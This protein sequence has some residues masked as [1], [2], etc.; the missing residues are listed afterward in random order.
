MSVVEGWVGVVEGGV[1]VV[2]GGAGCDRGWGW[3]W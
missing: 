3:V 2:K 1:V